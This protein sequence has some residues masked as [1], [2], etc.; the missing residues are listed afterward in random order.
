MGVPTKPTMT[1]TDSAET[2][3]Q[4]QSD[5]SAEASLV[6][7]SSPVL[8]LDDNKDE[9]KTTLSQE[10]EADIYVLRN[11]GYL[12]QYF[13]VGLIY[14]GLPATTYGFFLGYLSVPAHVYA[15]VRV[16]IVLPW[17]FKFAFG[18][19]ND[20]VPIAGYRRKPYM[21]IG[22]SLC[23]FMLIVLAFTPLPEPYWCLNG[24]L[25]DK[26]VPPCNPDAKQAGGGFA[27]LMILAAL[28]YVIAD[29]AADGLTVQFAR[30]EPLYRRGRIQTTAYMTRTVGVVLATLLVGFG[31]NGPEYNGTFSTGLSFSTICF[32]FAIPAAAM[33]PIS[34]LLIEEP[35][36]VTPRLIAVLIVRLIA[37]LMTSSSPSLSK[38][39][40][41]H[42]LIMISP[43]LLMST[44]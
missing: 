37:L 23:A 28:G 19:L 3:P 10:A 20:C 7:S 26:D 31:M 6:L 13:S 34:W 25:Q 32:I 12:A 43:D 5:E 35:R 4:L 22:W 33:A 18:L 42:Y 27:F 15:T 39:R 29:V 17:S 21:V 30:S 36:Q 11:I 38:R 40:S 41:P 24:T 16:I 14:G 44:P 2:S 9:S 8:E 1:A